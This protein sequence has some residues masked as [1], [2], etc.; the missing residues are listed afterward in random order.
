MI[1][2]GID[3]TRFGRVATGVGGAA[4]ARVPECAGPGHTVGVSNRKRRVGRVRGRAEN[5]CRASGDAGAGRGRRRG[6][7]TESEGVS[8]GGGGRTGVR[9]GGVGGGWRGGPG[10]GF[11]GLGGDGRALV[12]LNA[13]GRVVPTRAA[14]VRLDGGWLGLVRC[15]PW[16]AG[17][18]GGGRLAM[19]DGWCAPRQRLASTGPAFTP[20]GE[21][22]R[23]PRCGVQDFPG[24]CMQRA[25]HR[26]A[27]HPGGGARE[28]R[29]RLR[30]GPADAR[31]RTGERSRV[32]HMTGPHDGRD[33]TVRA[34]GGS[35]VPWGNGHLPRSAA[36]EGF[37][38]SPGVRAREGVR[39]RGRGWVRAGAP[40]PIPMAAATATP[41]PI[42]TPARGPP[43]APRLARSAVRRCRGRTLLPPR[44][45]AEMT[46]ATLPTWCMELG[47]LSC[48]WAILGSNQ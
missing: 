14:D 13:P 25:R 29:G 19:R 22:A 23:G 27:P 40:A 39:G 11:R 37:S 20:V 15:S 16:S 46:K 7:W 8:L 3:V 4:P 36:W 33:T 26:A 38:R 10:G 45:G 2:T 6:G 24:H 48:W 1:R 21:A 12:G 28:Q 30:G 5:N 31:R 17:R 47:R 41:A 34:E 32:V 35:G 43:P 44:G 18:R 9:V 42:P